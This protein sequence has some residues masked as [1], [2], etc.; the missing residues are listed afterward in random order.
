MHGGIREKHLKGYSAAGIFLGGLL[1]WGLIFRDLFN[2]IR[3]NE[4]EL[5]VRFLKEDIFKL[6]KVL[7]IPEFIRI[8]S[9]NLAKD[10]FNR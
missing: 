10:A 8:R 5:S 1:I 9:G 4:F 2:Y 7:R 3:W 6:V